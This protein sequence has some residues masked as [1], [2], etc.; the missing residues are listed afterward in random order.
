[1]PKVII[2]KPTP[3]EKSP[4]TL[5]DL[6]SVMESIIKEEFGVKVEVELFWETEANPKEIMEA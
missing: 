5:K 3:E 2:Q 4:T 6:A 1:M